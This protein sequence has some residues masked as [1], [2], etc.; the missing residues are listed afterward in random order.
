MQAKLHPWAAADQGRRFDGLFNLVHDPGDA[1][2][3]VRSGRG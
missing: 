1:A 2:D 3:G